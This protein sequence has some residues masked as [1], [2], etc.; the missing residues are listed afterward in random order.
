MKTRRKRL[1]YAGIFI[2]LAAFIGCFPTSK[3]RDPS[4]WMK[5][6]LRDT[7]NA[8]INAVWQLSG[9]VKIEKAT[10]DKKYSSMPSIIRTRPL[11]G[12]FSK[13]GHSRVVYFSTGDTLIESIIAIRAPHT[14]CYELTKPSLPMR[15]VAYRARGEF[16]Y[17]S[18]DSNRTVTVW[19]Y[20]FL[21]KN[22]ISKLFINNYI[23]S[24]HRLWMRD[25]LKATKERIEADYYSS[26]DSS[27]LK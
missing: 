14:F 27:T 20:S 13:A 21:N 23:N 4:K 9:K 3:N 17:S 19:T 25:M 1:T 18:L 22:L 15:L 16:D 24:T 26:S 5:V 12:D 11:V 6:I 2:L 10:A 7:V 8:P